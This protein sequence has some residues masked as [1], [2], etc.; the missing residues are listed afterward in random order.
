[1][2]LNVPFKSWGVSAE[3]DLPKF[4]VE[5]FVLIVLSST[6]GKSVVL[7]KVPVPRHV[8]VGDAQSPRVSIFAEQRREPS[9][10]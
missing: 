5:L 10:C 7:V 9:I 1:M 4:V 2:K 3:I 8:P 6:R